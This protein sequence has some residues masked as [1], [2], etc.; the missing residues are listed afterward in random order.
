MGALL[1]YVV[2]LG[3][4]VII[5]QVVPADLAKLY[6]RILPLVPEDLPRDGGERP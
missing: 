2:G 3:A 6:E 1:H 5:P 4:T